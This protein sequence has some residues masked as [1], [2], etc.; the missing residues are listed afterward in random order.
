MKDVEEVQQGRKGTIDYDQAELNMREKDEGDLF[1]IRAIEA[2]FYGGIAQSAPTSVANS[3]SGSRSASPAPGLRTP[4]GHSPSSSI[5]MTSSRPHTPSN[6]SPVKNF[7]GSSSALP[8]NQHNHDS[9]GPEFAH[10]YPG[11]F[12]STSHNSGMDMRR[13]MGHSPLGHTYSPK[14]RP[15]KAELTGRINHTPIDMSLEVPP[16]PVSAY[17]PSR[18]TPEY[19]GLPITSSSNSQSYPRHSVQTPFDRTSQ[20]S[21]SSTTSQYQSDTSEEFPPHGPSALNMPTHTGR[22]PFEVG[23]LSENSYQTVRSMRPSLVSRS[24]RSDQWLPQTAELSRPS[25]MKM[26]AFPKNAIIDPSIP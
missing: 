5:T 9:H 2:G 13:L 19:E 20:D 15:S 24:N 7:S 18:T 25:P 17:H 1:G 16:S 6:L 23:P 12:K 14:L 4:Q 21:T 11:G 26:P 3:P 10:H 8:L 22:G